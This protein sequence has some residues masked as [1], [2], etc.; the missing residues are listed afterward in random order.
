MFAGKVRSLPEWNTF[1]QLA[2]QVVKIAFREQNALAYLTAASAMKEKT[3]LRRRNQFVL[4]TF[5][6]AVNSLNEKFFAEL[7]KDRFNPNGCP[8]K[9]MEQHGFM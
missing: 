2:F 4:L 9:V 1:S 5:D 8:I 7:F 6:D 3:V